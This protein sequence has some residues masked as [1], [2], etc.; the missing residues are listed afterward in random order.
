MNACQT[1]YD[2]LIA[3][4]IKVLKFCISITLESI[5]SKE[6]LHYNTTYYQN[7]RKG[8]RFITLICILFTNYIYLTFLFTCI[9]EFDFRSRKISIMKGT[10]PLILLG[11]MVFICLGSEFDNGKLSNRQSDIEQH[12]ESRNGK[13]CFD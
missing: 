10:I 7:F 12:F 11:C 5:A 9:I 4:H 1:Q 3:T 6:S 8:N 2:F 13:L